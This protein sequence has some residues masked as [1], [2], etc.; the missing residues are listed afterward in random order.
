M[1]A[2]PQVPWGRAPVVKSLGAVT[3]TLTNLENLRDSRVILSSLD[4]RMLAR[5]VFPPAL[6]KPR[7]FPYTAGVTKIFLAASLR[8]T[9]R[10]SEILEATITDLLE[11]ERLILLKGMVLMKEA[12]SKKR[13]QQKKD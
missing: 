5:L 11:M 2:D 1:A 7:S 4:L 3:L 9:V 13:I 10:A 6:G 12:I 8:A